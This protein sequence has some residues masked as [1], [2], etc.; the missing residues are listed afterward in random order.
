MSVI[1]AI[2]RLLPILV[3]LI[4]LLL[5]FVWCVNVFKD[6]P[7]TNTIVGKDAKHLDGPDAEASPPTDPT[8]STA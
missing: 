4:A 2:L 6:S 1:V 7:V 8:D 3:V 5:L